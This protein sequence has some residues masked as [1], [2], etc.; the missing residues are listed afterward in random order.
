[1]PWRAADAL[2]FVIPFDLII[3]VPHARDDPTIRHQARNFRFR[4][5]LEVPP[6]ITYGAAAVRGLW[7]RH[8]SHHLQSWPAICRQFFDILRYSRR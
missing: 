3:V 2:A 8:S 4:Y 6:R 7:C 5:R 1:M